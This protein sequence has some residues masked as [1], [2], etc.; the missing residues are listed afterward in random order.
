MIVYYDIIAD[1]EVASDSYDSSIP[2]PGVRAITSKK[3]TV[4]EGVEGIASNADD[5]DESATAESLDDSVQQHIDIVYSARLS[6]INLDKKEYKTLQKAYWK[7]LID[8]L[9]EHKWTTLG[10]DHE[11]NQ[12]PT[13]KTAAAKAE[14]QAAAKLSS[15]DRRGYDELVSKIKSYKANFEGLQKF[16]NDEIL[17]NF[18]ECEFYTCEDAELGSCMIIPARYV[19]EATSPVFY[20]F[21]DGIKEKKE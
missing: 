21:T 12:P 10:Y 19:G 14:E 4:N 2:V 11:D 18:D 5:E 6:K 8:T 16:V 1:K 15:Y 7:K 3:I 9:N 20:L 17:A 13:D